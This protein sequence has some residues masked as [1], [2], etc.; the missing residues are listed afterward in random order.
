M[1]PLCQYSSNI[2]IRDEMAKTNKNKD[3]YKYQI[4]LFSDR[5]SLCEELFLLLPSLSTFQEVNF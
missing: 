4:E 1:Y 5:N 3:I 2:D